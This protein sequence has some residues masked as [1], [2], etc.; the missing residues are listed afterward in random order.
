MPTDV[1][2][3]VNDRPFSEFL[4]LMSLAPDTLAHAMAMLSFLFVVNY[5]LRTAYMSQRTRS[6]LT[7]MVV[8]TL[9]LLPAIALAVILCW[10]AY[11]HP[12]RAWINLGVAALLYVPWY[13]GGAMTRLARPDTEGGDIGWLTMGALITFPV[14]I[15]AALLVS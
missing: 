4:E 5:L 3:R 11:R 13:L 9:T 14:G 10:A 15:A 1:L 7:H 12:D 2:A 6:V 8:C